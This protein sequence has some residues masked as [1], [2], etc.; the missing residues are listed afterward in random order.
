MERKNSPLNVPDRLSINEIKKFSEKL[1]QNQTIAEKISSDVFEILTQVSEQN[2]SF[3][4]GKS[5]KGLISGLFYLLGFKYKVSP[6]QKEIASLLGTSDVTVR[7][8]YRIWLQGFPHLF[9]EITRRIEDFPM[10]VRSFLASNL[11]EGH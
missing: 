7:V 6:T 1:W 11:D 8:S 4:A 9:S 2:C 10:I 5:T 3:F